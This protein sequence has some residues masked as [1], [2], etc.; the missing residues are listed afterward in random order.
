M[1]L[2][3]VDVEADGPIPHNYSMVC[4]GAVRVD[5]ALQTTFYAKTR[6][7]SEKWIPSA[8][9]VSGFS[10]EDHL[11]FDDPA[12]AMHEFAAWIL[13]TNKNGRPIFVSDNNG[14]DWQWINWYFHHFTET[15]PFGHSS[16]RLGDMYAGYVRNL[17][18]TSGWKALRKTKHTHN[19]LQDALGV[20]E[21]LLALSRMISAKGGAD[22]TKDK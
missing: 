9:A 2:Y 20:A 22:L 4:F 7:I 14:F 11:K 10:R 18:D 8:L 1:S 17:K 3:V 6:P 5:D 19:P 21:G 16:R 12:K 15:N 13:K